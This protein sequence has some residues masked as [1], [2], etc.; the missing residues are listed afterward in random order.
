MGQ[1]YLRSAH[2][3][4]GN[5]SEQIGYSTQET[6]AVDQLRF[7]FFV[8]QNDNST[9]NTANIW[10]TNVTRQTATKVM[11]EYKK[12]KLS[13]GYQG[14][15][16]TLFEGDVFQARY[17]RE[18]LT[19]TI[20]HIIARSGDRARNDAVVNKALAAGHTFRDR[21]DI[22]VAA[23]KPFGITVGQID[24]FGSRKF[25]KGFACFGMAKDLLR[26]VCTATQSSWSIQ[27]NTLQIVK[28][29]G[30]LKRPVTVLNAS[31]GLIGLPVQTIQGIEG[32]CL[33]NGTLVPGS[34][35][36]I[37]QKSVQAAAFNPGYTS[38]GRAGLAE[39]FPNIATDGIYKLFEVNYNGDTRGQP[40]YAEFVGIRNGDAISAALA[41]RGIGDGVP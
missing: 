40:W 27:N 28:N 7:R 6:G 19:D 23:M 2:L 34:L 29:D 13:A 32:R 20:L 15:E 18:D 22:A 35:I 4:V 33:L 10:I 30:A 11:E 39:N 12:V 37:D 17:L 38:E 31:T 9:P 8:Q 16:Y 5:G 14:M 26:D 3:K 36:K 24:D 25:P 1:Q 21:V 41:A